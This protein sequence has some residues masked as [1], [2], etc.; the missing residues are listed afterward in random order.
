MGFSQGYNSTFIHW[1]PDSLL[2]IL[3]TK[4]SKDVNYFAT[5]KYLGS[6]EQQ[7]N[8]RR[9]NEH[10]KKITLHSHKNMM[11]L[12]YVGHHIQCS[13]FSEQNSKLR[14]LL[15]NRKELVSE[16]E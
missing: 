10:L 1:A 3:M 7:L 13:G 5:H 16:Q 8:G 12:S 2:R 9:G 14:V 6:L 4:N 11:Q 15:Q